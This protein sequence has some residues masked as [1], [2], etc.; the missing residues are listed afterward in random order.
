[1]W[2]SWK[3]SY[4]PKLS[5]LLSGLRLLGGCCDLPV[6]PGDV[7]AIICLCSQ[8]AEEER[9]GGRKEMI[10]IQNNAFLS[11]L[12]LN[13]V[14]VERS[15]RLVVFSNTKVTTHVFQMTKHCFADVFIYLF[16]K[17]GHYCQ[18]QHPSHWLS[19]HYHFSRGEESTVLLAC[20]EFPMSSLI[21]A[22]VLQ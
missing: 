2:R 13:M 7:L 21:H 8:E 11:H 17:R 16:G 9:S 14:E 5:G 22:T 15:Y 6:L 1:M 3:L 4:L 12:S 19:F 18:C 20:C 10:M